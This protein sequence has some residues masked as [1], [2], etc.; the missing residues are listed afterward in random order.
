MMATPAAMQSSVQGNQAGGDASGFLETKPKATLIEQGSHTS[1]LGFHILYQ[2]NVQNAGK[3]VMSS[4]FRML[5]RVPP[6][7]SA[8][9][10]NELDCGKKKLRGQLDLLAV[11]G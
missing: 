5:Q 2:A 9:S 6:T 4:V 3:G 8:H 1:T 11:V 10:L 7:G